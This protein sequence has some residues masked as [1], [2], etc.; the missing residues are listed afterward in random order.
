VEEDT[1]VRIVPDGSA[2]IVLGAD[3]EVFV[4]GPDTG[5]LRR[6]LRAGSVVVGLRFRP[7]AAGG[8]LGLPASELRDLRVPLD[9]I[10]KGGFADRSREALEAELLRRLPDIEAP[11]PLVLEAIRRLGR[12]G[13]RVRSL[14][15]ALFVSERHLRRVFHDAVGYGPKTL[16]RVLRFQRFLS[17]RRAGAGLAEAAAHL[18]YA[19][20]PHLTRETVRLSGLSPSQIS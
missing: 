2:D 17:L 6:S 11:E 10:W 14:S 8:A 12:P 19:D 15:D 4:A 18:G 7:G 1:L 13:S 5:P 16:D 3:G 20:Q 9:D